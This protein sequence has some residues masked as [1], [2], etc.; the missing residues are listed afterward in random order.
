L[1][2]AALGSDCALSVRGCFPAMTIIVRINMIEKI[3]SDLLHQQYVHSPFI[4]G[5]AGSV[6]VGKSSFSHHLQALLSAWPEHPQV[7]LISSDSFLYPAAILKERGIMNKKGFPESYDAQKLINF[8]QAIKKG[9]DKIQ[10]PVYSHEIYDITHEV[11]TISSPDILI[12]EGVNILEYADHLDFTIFIDA[13]TELIK[14]WYLERFQTHCLQAKNKSDSYFYQ[15]TLMPESEALAL[16]EN[17]WET[18]NAVNLREN[19]LP[20]KHKA[21]LILEKGASHEF[22]GVKHA[23]P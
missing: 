21:D 22:L 1:E 2:G 12:M 16:A 19:I 7:D 6:A 15:F 13:P 8:L 23:K 9:A 17:T 14:T 3:L 20:L 4:I 5:I 18:I 10:V 11:Q